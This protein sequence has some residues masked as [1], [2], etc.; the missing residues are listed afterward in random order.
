MPM[1]AIF[2]PLRQLSFGAVLA[3]LIVCSLCGTAI[4]LERSSKNRTAGF[5]THILVCL[6]GTVAALVGLFLYLGLKMPADITR[7]SGQIITGLGFIGAGSIIITKKMTIKGLTTA[8]GLWTCGI[9]G[10]AIGSGFYEGGILG[11][12]LVLLAETWF[13]KL[14][15]RIQKTPEF[16]VRVWYNDKGALDEVLRYFKD[17]HLAIE[18]LKIRSQQDMTKGRYAA[19]ITVRGFCSGSELVASV[20]QMHGVVAVDD[21]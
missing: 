13:V 21:I 4:G 11:T 5:R 6:A 9:I 7:I 12:V 10:V 8:A 1:L 14:R 17:K 19:D 18:N 15:G 20:R 2:D 16:P 3:K